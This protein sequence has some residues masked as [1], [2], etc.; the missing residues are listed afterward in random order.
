MGGVAVTSP[1][2]YDHTM[3]SLALA[4]ALALAAVSAAA[5]QA[6]HR[7]VSLNL[8]AD[9]LLLRLADRDQ[10]ASLS[11]FAHDARQSFLVEEARALPTN[12]G[13]GEQILM[14]SVDLVI[15]GRFDSKPKLQLLADKGVPTLLLDAWRDLD[16]GRAQIRML[17]ER[18]GHPERGEA[19]IAEID[20]ALARAKRVAPA[21]RTVLV[22]FRRGFVLGGDNF[23]NALLRHV[24][25]RPMQ[26]DL[27]RPQGGMVRLETLVA[28]PP[29]YAMI[30]REGLAAVD[31]GTA[32]LVHPALLDVLPPERRITLDN[33]LT[34]CGGPSTPAA[35]DALAAEV[36]AKVR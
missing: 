30:G 34:T 3:R 11:P 26:G 8:C 13:S 12:G 18:L 33:K 15:A 1:T 36:R 28:T 14:Q 19:L 23:M 7:I 5:A 24:G 29:D 17:A 2:L 31:N 10:I 22:M 20:A 25:L 32:F 16:H 4:F 27:G 21:E 35:I 9:Q 6:P